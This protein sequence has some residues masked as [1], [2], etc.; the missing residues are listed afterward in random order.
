M[1]TFSFFLYY[2]LIGCGNGKYLTC[3]PHTFKLGSDRS[4]KLAEIAGQRAREAVVAECM[5]VCVYAWACN[6][7]GCVT[8]CLF[9]CV[10]V[11]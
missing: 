3:A 9:L 5:Q 4:I 8:L 1:L 7:R 10:C 11:C 2:C 6:E